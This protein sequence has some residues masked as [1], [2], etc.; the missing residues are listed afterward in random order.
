MSNS[1]F[2]EMRN[3]AKNWK[4]GLVYFCAD[5]P[6]VVVRNRFPLGWTWNFANRWVPLGIVLSIVVFVSPVAI[7]WSSGV[8]S[9]AVMACLLIA[10]LCILM[11]VAHRLSRDPSEN[12]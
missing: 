7:A 3:D 6:R 12:T 11:L 2:E 8:R 1:K 4:L 9:G 5:D 10:S